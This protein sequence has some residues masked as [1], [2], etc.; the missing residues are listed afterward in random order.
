MRMVANRVSK[1]DIGSFL[2]MATRAQTQREIVR[3]MRSKNCCTSCFLGLLGL[4][5]P[6]EGMEDVGV[7]DVEALG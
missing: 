3:P 4:P 7:G 5:M 6:V 1:M 2:T